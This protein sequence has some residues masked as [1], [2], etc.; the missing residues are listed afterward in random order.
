MKLVPIG[1]AMLGDERRSVM[2]RLEP[3]CME[4]I[5]KLEKLI[6]DRVK[7]L[8]GSSP[9]VVT[10]PKVISSIK[11]SKEVGEYFLKHGVRVLIL[12]YYIWDYPYLVWPLVNIVGKDKPILN[13]SNNEGEYPGNVGLLA[14]DGALRQAGL[15]TYRIIGDLDDPKIQD[16]IIKWVY[17]AEA[18]ASLRGQVYG[19]YGGHSMG[20]ETG[21]FHMIPIQKTFG[22]TVYQIDQLWLVKEMEKVPEEE[23]E[24]GFRWLSELLGDRIKYDGKMLTPEKLKT[25]LRL[26]LAMK[27]VNE[28]WGFDF[29]GIKGQRDL[30]EHVII[31]D[32]AEM[33]MNDPYDW[34]GR[35]EPFV[36]ATEADSLGALTMQILKYVSG[37]LPVL[38]ADVR[39]YV[40][41]KDIWIFANSGNHS[42]YYAAFSLDPK[43][44][45]KKIT[46]WPAIEMY[47]PSGGAS[48]EF[49]AAPGEMTF[50]RLGIR[51]DKL[52]MVIVR[53]ESL[54]LP[55]EEKKRLKE[56][57]N[58]TWPHMYVKLKAS[59][60]EFINVFPANHIHGV[61]GNRVKELVHFCHIAGIKPIVLGEDKKRFLE[62][63]WEQ[64]K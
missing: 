23:V 15:R 54:D 46:L 57:T 17:A 4:Q 47:F 50:A 14:T 11:D 2:E 56:Q 27:K 28:E 9:E 59:Y 39:L 52:Y 12:L 20:M 63:L 64:V 13:V 58:P 55:E 48:V 21:Y 34:N 19:M 62:P 1:I 43:E 38:F 5:H 36:C 42:S 60:E 25:Q 51:D 44:N 37:G 33:I 24:K 40:P 3:R 22:V 61:P 7:Y 10:A 41:E 26:Y 53:G 32:V 30:T 45:F 29:C 31:T 8:D 35:K 16:E 18:Y 6:K 49:D